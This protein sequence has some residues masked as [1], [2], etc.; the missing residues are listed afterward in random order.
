MGFQGITELLQL[1]RQG[2]GD[3]AARLFP[4]VNDELRR[5]AAGYFRDENP[6][7]T[8][9]PTALVHDLYLKLSTR[10]I[11]FKDRRHFYA[12]AARQMR[13]LLIDHARAAKAGKRGGARARVELL[14]EHGGPAGAGFDALALHEALE[15][16]EGLDSRVAS[17]VE[18]RYFA[19]LTETEAAEALDISLA[20][21]KRD[22]EFAQAWLKVRLRP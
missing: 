7:H 19:G 21:F 4:L 11:Q 16:L 22:W 18:L 13:H 9:Q 12:I 15:V 8:L 6:G 14:Q 5:I 10:S 2:D 20:T 3:V 17:G 1:W